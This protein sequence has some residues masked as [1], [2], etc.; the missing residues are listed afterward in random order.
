M[1]TTASVTISLNITGLGQASPNLSKSFTGTTP[2]AVHYDYRQLAEADAAE[3]LDL[4]DVST[5]EGIAI[6]AASKDLDV[7]CDFVDAFDIDIPIAEGQAAYFKPEGTVYVKNATGAEQPIYE[8]IVF[9][10]R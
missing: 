4:G 8:Y 7:D 3:A 2:D 1:T 10:T 6:Y 5:V 9:G